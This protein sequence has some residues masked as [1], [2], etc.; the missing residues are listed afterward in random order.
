MLCLDLAWLQTHFRRCEYNELELDKG[1]RDHSVFYIEHNL[2][3]AVSIHIFP[4]NYVTSIINTQQRAIFLPVSCP[5]TWC[6]AFYGF[7]C[8]NTLF[9]GGLSRGFQLVVCHK[10]AIVHHFVW[11]H[12]WFLERCV[13]EIRNISPALLSIYSINAKRQVLSELVNIYTRMTSS[14]RKKWIVEHNKLQGSWFW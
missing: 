5:L 14:C 7:L 6:D 11:G 10:M 12:S 8:C 3:I 2:I 9:W 4:E 13:V 1:A